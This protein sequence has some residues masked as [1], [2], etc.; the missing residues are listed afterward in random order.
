MKIEIDTNFLRQI[1]AGERASVT[2][3]LL[4]V[5]TLVTITVMY[6]ANTSIMLIKGYNLWYDYV[7]NLLI[8]FG[9]L[10]NIYVLYR[11]LTMQRLARVMLNQYIS[12]AENLKRN[13]GTSNGSNC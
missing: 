7:I 3:V 1:V 13:S 11:E 4:S 5:L 8:L 2:S 10:S 12:N 6:I 9:I